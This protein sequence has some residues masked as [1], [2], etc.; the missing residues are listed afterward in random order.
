MNTVDD[1]RDQGSQPVA[2]VC[3]KVDGVNSC[4]VKEEASIG[5]GKGFSSSNSISIMKCETGRA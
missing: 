1:N 5:V 3:L 4:E 2:S